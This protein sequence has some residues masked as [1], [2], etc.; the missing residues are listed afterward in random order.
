MF[1]VDFAKSMK[2][3]LFCVDKTYLLE[4]DVP[5]AVNNT[6]P[7]RRNLKPNWRIKMRNKMIEEDFKR[8]LVIGNETTSDRASALYW[9]A[10]QS[11]GADIA[12][13]RD[14]AFR[15]G[16]NKAHGRIKFAAT[17]LKNAKYLCS[18]GKL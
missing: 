18:I 2:M 13:A 9:I 5:H 1:G 4:D 3:Y 14:Q 11:S 17:H 16:F 8:G 12:S 7:V 6:E 15:A 10:E